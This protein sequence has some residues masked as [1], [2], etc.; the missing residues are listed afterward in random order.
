MKRTALVVCVI[1][2]LAS[3]VNAQKKAV[4]TSSL[5]TQ[6][7][8]VD[9]TR[10]QILVTRTFDNPVHRIAVLIRAADLLWPYDQDKARATFIEAFD[11]A[12]QNFKENGEQTRHT[13]QSQFAAV[14]QLPDQRSRLA[15]AGPSLRE[16]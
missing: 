8:A 2:Y 13:S 9:T 10:Q 12:V 6:D 15:G 1:L 16:V 7:Y 4:T 3:G 5:C 11:L 14:V